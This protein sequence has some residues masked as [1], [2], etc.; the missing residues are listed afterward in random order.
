V[1]FEAKVVIVGITP[2][3]T[4]MEIAFR[5]ARA[6]LLKGGNAEVALRTVKREA[7]FAGAMRRNLIKMLNEIRLQKAMG[8]TSCDDLFGCNSDLIHPTSAIRHPVF[9]HG[10][11]YTG[12]SPDLLCEAILLRYV[13][14]VF[15][16]ELAA[17][18]RALVVPLGSCVDA[19]LRHLINIGALNPKRCLLGFPH[20]S[21]ANGHRPSQFEQRR[22]GFV[23]IVE[24][25]ANS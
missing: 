24:E 10:R 13:E 14:L 18:P 21:G 6:A 22:N 4:Q 23:R 16:T 15:A 2:G 5:Q 20:P 9:V 7:S 3:W 1:N 8:Q 25:W 12:H 11:N 17:M 19:V